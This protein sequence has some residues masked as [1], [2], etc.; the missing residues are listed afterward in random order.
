MSVQSLFSLKTRRSRAIVTGCLIAILVPIALIG[1]LNSGFFTSAQSSQSNVVFSSP[2]NLS[3]DAYNAQYPWVSTSGSNVYVAW[4]E[5]AHGIYFRYSNNYG[6]TWTPSL[7]SAAERLSQK[8]GTTS[9]PVMEANGSNVY[10]AWTQT[11]SSG[12]NGEIFVATSNNYGVTFNTTSAPTIELSVNLTAYTG[13]IPYIAAYGS[14]VYVIW[15]EV[16]TS[17]A[18]ESVWVSSSSNAGQKWTTALELDAKSGQADE[19][20]IAAWGTY[21]YATWDR[22]GPYFSYTSNNGLTWSTPVNLN[23]GSKTVPAGTTREPWI[24]ASGSNVYVTWNDN[25]GY[26][27]TLG[28]VYDPYIMVS[29][30]NG[31]TWNQNAPV[32]GVKLNLMPNSSSSWEIQVQAVENTVYVVWRD[33]TPAYTTNGGVLYMYST[34]AGET[35]TPSLDSA[36]PTNVA[37]NDN[38]IKGW[39]N[40]IGVSGNTV[41]VAYL[42]DCTTGLQEP[43]PNSGSGDCAMQAV[44]SNNGGQ[45][46]FPEVNISD[47]K[48]SGPIT[49]ISSS[50]FAV[51]GS[52]VFVTWQDEAASN[53]Q[54]YFSATNGT[55]VQS[56][57]F[58]ATPVRGAVGTT[59]TVTGDNFEASLPITISFDS[60]TIATTE[61]NGSGYFSTTITI[62]AATAGSNTITATDGTNTLSSNFNV[63]PNISLTPVKGQ[64][65]SSVTVTG[66]GFAATS[67]VTVMF[68]STKVATTTTDG[69]GNF[70][71]S[72]TVPSGSTGSNTVTATDSSPSAN[73]ATATFNVAAP[74]ITLS[75]I[76]GAV[77]KSVV[78]T[79]TGFLSSAT[80]T[81]TYDNNEIITTTSNSTGGFVAPAFT[82]PASPYGSN[83]VNATDGTF[84]AT[85]NFNV[86]PN[87]SIT[88]KTSAGKNSI[89]VAVTG[90]GYDA[91]SA[92]TITF[93][94]TTQTTTPAIVTT[95]SDGS[96][97]ATFVVPKTTPA[98]SYT[99]QATD[100]LGNSDSNPPTFKVN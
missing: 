32:K 3:N 30:N 95:G 70:S 23:P 28:D 44:Y 43:S 81:I 60:V 18:A 82:V 50:N 96:F 63:V 22:N 36:I 12:G 87:L 38:S 11:L 93:G 39:T 66:N 40:G 2:V 37:S 83:M 34:N 25:S 99:V 8:G 65:G 46:F 7:T 55:V 33:H 27:T 21:A 17:T 94:G 24:S 57:S 51:S 73:T 41:A 13:D 42:S 78:V 61:S 74:K 19:P 80:I 45:S 54:V 9:Y 86:V 58:S 89:T 29:N 76:K 49:D 64:A 79:G 71:A 31:Q 69:V 20:Q 68:G 10:V 6:V 67:G 91:N 53:F 35:W 75:P 52:Y 100:G 77:G 62:P 88:P 90:T 26:G 97:T 48:T 85:A 47:D 92:V 56:S 98:G 14:D 5:E 16:D 84:S 4:T 1:A 59:V 72:F 15:H